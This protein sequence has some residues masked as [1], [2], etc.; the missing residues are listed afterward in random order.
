MATQYLEMFEAPTSHASNHS[1]PYSN[2]EF[3]DRWEGMTE[4]TQYSNLCS[5]PE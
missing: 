1:N 5:N 2:S 4:T 3:E